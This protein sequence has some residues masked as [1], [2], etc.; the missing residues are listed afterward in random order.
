MRD[1]ILNVYGHSFPQS[2]RGVTVTIDDEVVGIAG[3]LYTQPLQCFSNIDDKLKDHPR[4]IIKA[5]KK[6]RKI[7]QSFTTPVFA[8]PNKEESTADNFLT[9]I[10]FK[11]LNDEV[12][13]WTS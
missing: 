9:H 1:D 11:H 4:V 6:M 8:F 2:V 13:V 12:F 5:I 7:L 3:V 10:G